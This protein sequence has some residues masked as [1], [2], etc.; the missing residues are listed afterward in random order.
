MS[1]LMDT[2]MSWGVQ[3]LRSQWGDG[4]GWREGLDLGVMEFA[5]DQ[6]EVINSFSYS[7]I[8]AFAFDSQL[9]SF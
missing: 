9:S 8:T 2:H 5:G 4:D 7:L 1:G 3:R 6:L